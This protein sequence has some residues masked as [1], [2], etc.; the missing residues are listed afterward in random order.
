MPGWEPSAGR[1]N[2]GFQ[3]GQ[4]RP[5]PP[6]MSDGRNQIRSLQEQLGRLEGQ[7]NMRWSVRWQ[8]AGGFDHKVPLHIGFSWG[9]SAYVGHGG[10]QKEIQA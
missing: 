3:R 6:A 8:A 1:R 10:R 5:P 9:G 7:R 2:D 4:D